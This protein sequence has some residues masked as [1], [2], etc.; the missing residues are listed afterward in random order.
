MGKHSA[1]VLMYRFKDRGLEVFLVHPGGPFW[2]KKDEH[3]WS[4]PKGELSAGET[5]L[6]AARREFE[7]ETSMAVFSFLEP[8]GSGKYV[9]TI[10]GFH[11]VLY[12]N[13]QGQYHV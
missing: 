12:F 9:A 3:A 6:E 5:P 7:E 2:T 13:A 8:S 4:I 11:A 10:N 1:G